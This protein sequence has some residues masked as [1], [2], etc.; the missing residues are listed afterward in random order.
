[1]VADNERLVRTIAA[2][3]VGGNRTRGV[4]DYPYYL[5]GEPQVK[6]TSGELLNA[7]K[8][9]ARD[10][11]AAGLSPTVSASTRSLAPRRTDVLVTTFDD[12][13]DTND[14]A[15]G[16]EVTAL[17]VSVPGYDG[18]REAVAV[19]HRPD[20][21]IDLVVAAA[22]ADRAA[23]IVR[24]LGDGSIRD[25]ALSDR[26]AVVTGPVEEDEGE[27]DGATPTPQPTPTP[28]NES[29]TEPPLPGP[30]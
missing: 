21:P 12:L 27:S 24:A 13:E 22:S 25:D 20:G 2:F 29:T 5:S 23:D 3:A 14:P 4:A 17:S 8:A 6:Y 10:L 30:Q 1:V 9:V 16:I 28:T 26:T 19:V 7:S 18:D 11:R 15:T